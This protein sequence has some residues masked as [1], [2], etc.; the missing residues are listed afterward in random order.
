[1]PI[2]RINLSA[3]N[4]RSHVTLR[5]LLSDRR[6]GA[7]M[8]F[9]LVAP[10]VLMSVGAAIDYSLFTRERARLQG[11]VDA[12]AIFSARELQMA[13]ADSQKISAIAQNFVHAEEPLATV[14]TQVD[15]K[16]FSVTVSARKAFAPKMG[17][18]FWGTAPSVSVSATAKLNGTAPLCLLALDTS[19][20]ATVHL[21]QSAA[22]TATGCM[23]Y[24]NS[25]SPSGLQARDSATL[26][27]GVVCTAG[28]KAKTSGATVTP[29]PV[30]DCPVMEDPLRARIAP[31]VGACRFDEVVIK[32]GS[33]V[34]EPGVY[35]K[36]LKITD[37]A[38]VT[39]AKGT[40]IIKDGP[41]IVEKGATLNGTDISIFLTGPGSNLTFAAE[42]TIN[43]S[44]AKDGPLAGLL[45]FD[46]PSGA[47]ALAIPPFP[48]PIPIVG[49]LLGGLGGLVGGL[50]PPG[51]PREHKI[52]SDN[53]R[54]L[55]GT[56][57][58]P[59]GRLIV[60]AS[61]PI[62]DKS[63]YT[64]IVVRR[65]DLHAGPNLILNSDYSATDVPVPKGVGPYGSNVMLTN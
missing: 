62:A 59:Q 30:T 11:Q 56:I 14:Q 35:C 12:A 46:D 3:R 39:L 23:V 7:A 26:K 41:L 44:A 50:L 47:K 32:G 55:L 8:T 19:A 24:S 4:D 22:M 9:G 64:V 60:D 54:M 49:Q 15:V 63:A 51:P 42:T 16:A 57:Y 37:G 38:Q 20:P 31:T 40:F 25:K 21:E 6:A 27:A 5:W 58:M 13:K 1:M 33:Q 48:L 36:G 61:K 18:L 52:L 45:I 17:N 2:P 43:L 65:I 10:V 28:G 34:L 29:E 53:A